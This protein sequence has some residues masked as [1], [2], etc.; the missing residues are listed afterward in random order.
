M[1]LPLTTPLP[2]ANEDDP[3]WILSADNAN[4]IVGKI[5][6]FSNI[7]ADLPLKIVKSDAGMK[8]VVVE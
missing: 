3:A 8:I 5:E 6:A 2:L 1:P 4:L 7:Q